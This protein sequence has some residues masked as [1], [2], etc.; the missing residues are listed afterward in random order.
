M[1]TAVNITLKK[2]YPKI[3][4]LLSEVR[5]QDSP[6]AQH[7]AIMHFLKNRNMT[8]DEWLTLQVLI[9]I[10]KGVSPEA[11][12]KQIGLEEGL[13]DEADLKW[14]HQNFLTK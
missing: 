12:G 8:Q 1:R 3:Y 2:F 13:I 5:Q 10:G 14:L 9:G 4:G 7:A 11:Y 6:E